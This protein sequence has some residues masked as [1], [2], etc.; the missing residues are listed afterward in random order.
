MLLLLSYRRQMPILKPGGQN[1]TEGVLAFFKPLEAE[2]ENMKTAI[3][4]CTEE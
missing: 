3:F 2:M 4:L 1:M